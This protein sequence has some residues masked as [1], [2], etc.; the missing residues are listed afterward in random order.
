MTPMH[1]GR[2]R[3][4]RGRHR[5]RAV[6]RASRFTAALAAA[7]VALV[8]GTVLFGL[9]TL[10]H[11]DGPAFSV[12]PATELG[13]Q[14]FVKATWSGFTK[15]GLVYF[16]EC[17]QSPAQIATDCT[18]TY[19]Q[20]GL[21][22]K[23][24]AG[25]LYL[26]VHAGDVYAA[27]ADPGQPC[28]ES[29]PCFPCDY[30]T[31]CQLAAF[32][33]PSTLPPMASAEIQFA[34]SPDACPPPSG[35]IVTGSGSSA[36]FRAMTKWETA[37]CV[38]PTNLA[39]N[40]TLGSSVDGQTNFIS[41][42]SDFGVS[43]IPFNDDQ[44]S[45]LKDAKKTFA[46]APL[47]TSGTVLAYQ[48]YQQDPKSFSAGAQITD[49][50]LTPD[51]VAKVF[52]GQIINWHQDQEINDLNPSHK[53]L[54]PPQVT[55][56]YRAASS[57][58]TWN[59]TSWLWATAQGSMPADWQ[60]SCGCDGPTTTF[61]ANYLPANNGI[62]EAD[63][64]ALTIADPGDNNF[65][66]D[67]YTWGYLGFVDSSLA[68]YYGLPEVQIENAAGAF[69][70]ATPDAVAAALTHVKTNP[71][72]VTV[73]PDYTNTDPAQYPMPELSYA[74]VPTNVTGNFD[75]DKG[76]TLTSFLT[77]AVTDGQAAV[78]PG[79]FPV[80]KSM[81]DQAKTAIAKIPSNSNPPPTTP[82]PRTTPPPHTTPPYT[83][84]YT[85]PPS[86]Y[87]PPT[88]EPSLPST[89]PSPTGSSSTTPCPSASPSAAATPVPGP[90]GP[91]PSGG[92][93]SGGASASPSAEP[94]AAAS[95]CAA[96]GVV[97]TLPQAPFTTTFG[98]LAFPSLA[99]LG[100]VGLSAG[101][102][103]QAYARRRDE[104]SKLEAANA[105]LSGVAGDSV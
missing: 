59:L 66:S 98:R 103:M 81:L 13:D 102:A 15:K 44:L 26:E 49:L 91:S 77:Y 65:S 78:P 85:P 68:A 71:D 37:E 52:T 92:A 75:L 4:A 34:L 69:V 45:Q 48:I 50:K 12:D 22:D 20:T 5:A 19:T 82:P 17:T 76:D 99:L 89:T 32:E 104:A 88:T 55:S 18:P 1:R 62:T 101:P 42:L 56:L 64:L 23:T 97:A 86:G 40:Y 3:S 94:T 61:P 7:S 35:S 27:G 36:A 24:G 84:G 39:V 95:P 8:A 31:P 29:N 14:Q 60:A 43:G 25:A 73:S 53:G 54:F 16:R 87:T 93:P 6:D 10:A 63:K 33:D 80:P 74:I 30:Q 79:Y 67:F 72:G 57:A 28:G 11:A 58:S 96:V 51:L 100:I 70:T 47:S 90:T 41:G 83:G 2:H 105:E 46:Y 38:D 21:S 9:P